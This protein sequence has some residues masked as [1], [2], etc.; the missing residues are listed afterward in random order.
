MAKDRFRGILLIFGAVGAMIGFLS[1]IAAQGWALLAVAGHAGRMGLPVVALV[2]AFGLARRPELLI[3][4]L[5]S[6]TF[7]G[8]G[9]YALGWPGPRPQLF[10]NL[11]FGTIGLEASAAS[12]FLTMVGILNLLAAV[13]VFVRKL[14]MSML[15]Y[16]VV[17][18]LMTSLAYPWAYLEFSEEQLG[19]LRWSSEFLTRLPHALLPLALLRSVVS[20]KRDKGSPRRL[21]ISTL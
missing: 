21:D 17:W 13:L 4:I 1:I 15:I 19:W 9:S 18:G 14:A 5:V 3:Y 10:E 6:L 16:M 7:L 20:A 2:M 8:H 12:I 11:V